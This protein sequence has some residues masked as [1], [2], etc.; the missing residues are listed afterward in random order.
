MVALELHLQTGIAYS[1]TASQ[2]YA[3]RMCVIRP[4]ENVQIQ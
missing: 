2:V 4:D 1:I 3:C